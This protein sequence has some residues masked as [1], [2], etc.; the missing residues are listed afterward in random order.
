[1]SYNCKF[2]FKNQSE[3]FSKFWVHSKAVNE[4]HIEPL[5]H[6]N[7]LNFLRISV[8]Y[9]TNL[10]FLSSEFSSTKI[11]K[12][13]QFI[14]TKFII[15][16]TSARI[17][18]NRITNVTRIDKNLKK[19]YLIFLTTLSRANLY[20]SYYLIQRYLISYSYRSDKTNFHFLIIYTYVHWKKI[21]KRNARAKQFRKR[22]FINHNLK[23]TNGYTIS[24][25]SIQ[26]PLNIITIIRFSRRGFSEKKKKRKLKLEWIEYAKWE[27]HTTLYP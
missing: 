9:P 8:S 13:T 1:M 7:K 24:F 3:I 16:V 5:I 22:T 27:T 15:P 11:D 2:S 19:K 21:N 17:F 10:I 26:F 18:I 12:P 25:L 20:L 4:V 14:L 23:S 6:L